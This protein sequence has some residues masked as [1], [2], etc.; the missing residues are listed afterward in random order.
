MTKQF[1]ALKEIL[2][3]EWKG[4]GFAKFPTIASTAYTESLIFKQDE[5]KDAIHY[6]Q[7]TWYKNDTENNGKTVFWDTGFLLLKEDKVLFVSAQ[8]GGRL[9]TYELI[10]D[11]D[12]QFVFNSMIISNDP[13]TI[14]SQRILHLAGSELT[15]E[16]NMNTHQ[17]SE[18]QN[19][20]K[21]TLKK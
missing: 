5:N 8:S 19:H 10:S 16:L 18:F 4:E 2:P 3:G 17:A 1:N 21:A 20:L 14:R 9:E 13:K 7:K 11:R 6:V 12:Q 15:Y